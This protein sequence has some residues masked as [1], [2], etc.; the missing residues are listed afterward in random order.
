MA[1]VVELM[2]VRQ[3]VKNGFVLAGVFFTDQLFELEPF[4]DAVVATIVFCL[5][6]SAVYCLNDVVDREADAG[7]PEKAHRPVASGAISV[8]Y[9]LTLMGVLLALAG[10]VALVGWLDIRACGVIGAYVVMNVAYSLRFKHKAI[11]DVSM[12]A[13]G[14]VLRLAAGAYAVDVPPSS[15]VVL[16]TGLLALF[17]ALGKRRGDLTREEKSVRRSLRGYSLGFI[18]QALSMTGASTVVVYAL[19]TVS[20]YA[21]IRFDAP[22]LYL[23]T[24]PVAIGVLRFM[25]MVMVKGIYGSPT[26]VVLRDRSLQ[27]VGLVFIGSFAVLVYT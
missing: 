1:K 6:S 21:Q 25:Q 22:Y 11:V 14:F 17:L 7:H 19:F 13:A 10:L 23:T 3:W 4:V 18:D 5:A 24:F 26:D 15:W 8:R 20:D 12:I 27:L 9:A 16:C 2:R